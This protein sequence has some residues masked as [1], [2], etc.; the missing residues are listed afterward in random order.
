MTDTI[1]VAQIWIVYAAFYIG[2]P[3]LCMIIFPK[4]RTLEQATDDISAIVRSAVFVGL[5]WWAATP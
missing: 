3:V 1:A 4:D 5:L 2:V